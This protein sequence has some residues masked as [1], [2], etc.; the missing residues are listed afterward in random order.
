MN[1]GLG[2]AQQIRGHKR[3]KKVLNR[4]LNRNI[5]DLKKV[6]GSYAK[7]YD[8]S[9]LRAPLNGNI[10]EIKQELEDIKNSGQQ[11]QSL[12]EMIQQLKEMKDEED[13]R[14]NS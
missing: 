8:E 13:A 7:W 2:K 3:R 5:S 12:P 11:A 6:E 9:V 14:I 10:D 4:S 1:K